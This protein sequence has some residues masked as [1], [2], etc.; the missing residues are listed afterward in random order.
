MAASAVLAVAVVAPAI[1]GVPAIP[2]LGGGTPEPSAEPAA[3]WPEGVAGEV[4]WRLGPIEEA[5]IDEAPDGMVDPGCELWMAYELAGG[6]HGGQSVCA[7][8]RGEVMVRRVTV[9]DADGELLDLLVVMASDRRSSL[10]LELFG[11][12]RLNPELHDLAL[13]EG[14]PPISLGVVPVAPGTGIEH[15]GG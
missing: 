2:Y 1:G 13:L 9:S 6:D 8:K 11:E 4:A 10:R 7:P 3:A 14:A 15:M 5:A 12:D